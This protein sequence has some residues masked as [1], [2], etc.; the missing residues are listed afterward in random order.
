MGWLSTLNLIRSNL[1][2]SL[3]FG[4]VWVGIL[5]LSRG[6]WAR[7]VI[8][9]LMHATSLVYAVVVTAAHHVFAVTGSSLD[10]SLIELAITSFNELRPVM[11]SEVFLLS[12]AV[13]CAY[14]LFGPAL[15]TLA[16]IRF[17]LIPETPRVSDPSRRP[18]L[19]ALPA[20]GVLLLLAS[21]PVSGPLGKSF[22]RDPLLHVLITAV[23]QPAADSADRLGASFG[24]VGARLIRKSSGGPM[25]IALIVLESTGASSVTPYNKGIAT[26]PYLDE[27]A[28]KSLLVERTYS[29]V[30][31]TSKA[32]VSIVCGIEPR[33]IRPITEFLSGLIPATCLPELLR[34]QGYRTVFFQSATEFFQNRRR[35]VANFG[36]EDFY[37]GESMDSRGFERANYFGFEDDVML[38]PSRK[39]LEKNGNHPFLATYLTITPHHQY[40]APRRYGRVRFVQREE[41]NLY[42]NAVRYLDFFV[43]NLIEQYQ[44]LGL[45]DETIFVIVGDHG[46]AF[47]EHRRS[48]HNNILYEEVMRVPLLI[49]SPAIV[50]AGERV[51][52]PASLLDILPTAV[53]LLGFE[54]AKGSY[55]GSSIFS[56]SRDRPLYFSCF[57]ERKCLG[58][59]SGWLKFIYYYDDQPDQLFDLLADPLE[60]E[61]LAAA[62]TEDVSS[63]RTELQEWRTNLDATYR[64]HHRDQIEPYLFD[65]RPPIQHEVEAVFAQRLA[66]VG[67]DLSETKLK[68]GQSFRITYYF[69]VRQRIPRKWRIVVEALGDKG[70]PGQDNQAERVR[71]EHHPLDGLYLSLEAD[72]HVFAEALVHE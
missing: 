38:E 6:G 39:W 46:E 20:A 14:S 60:R 19:Y 67:Y 71:L 40:L 3:G 65:S 7:R 31:H 53:D 48:K 28:E 58:S 63:R 42:L 25:N 35:L 59:L 43:R 16:A 34:Q 15:S 51:A 13:V 36:Y 57:R 64:Q 54:I 69:E 72:E 44:Q 56:L 11:A 26:T 55:P 27:L 12:F 23:D 29:T 2:F 52:G 8:V 17:H 5:A 49:H 37:P 4:V 50:S 1:L 70:K 30:P 61:N 22:A 32:L 21:V 9:A 33:P 10:Y 68:P 24:A 47:G 66:L 45:Y 18:A 62:A 41:H